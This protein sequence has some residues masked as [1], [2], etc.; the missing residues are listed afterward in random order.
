MG[1]LA[2]VALLLP[3]AGVLI[4][5]KSLG[6]VRLGETP[7]QV[8][9]TWGRF[10]GTCHGCAH[11]TWYFTYARFDRHGAGVEFRNGR[12]VAVFTLWQPTGWRS[13]RGL[14]LGDA[15][16]RVTEIYG[17][18]PQTRCTRHTAYTLAR[19]NVA[20]DFDVVSD[21]VWAFALRRSGVSACR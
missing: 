12:V 4:P 1:A 9:R 3:Q 2:L 7:A 17:A 19:G 21:G 13:S 14:L 20:T 18:L 11:K 16:A 8:E 15:S 6:G 5:G 10:H